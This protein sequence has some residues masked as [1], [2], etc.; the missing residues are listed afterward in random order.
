MPI[1]AFG[2]NNLDKSGY[3]F[4]T[5][6][7]VQN[8]YGRSN[9]IEGNI[10]EDINLK[11][12]DRIEKLPDPISIREAA[13]KNYVDK[14]FND[15]SIIRNTAHVDFND[16]NL[17][18]VRFIKVISMPALGKHLTASYYVDDA[19]YRRV[20]EPSLLRLDPD[21]KL[22]LGKQVSIFFILL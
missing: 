12:Q 1:N 20:H 7:F 16:K 15:P 11:N 4:D 10:Q 6:L 18:N 2:N 14:K 8:P 17:D 13:S 21:E 19:I 3:K 22:S 5:S 9:Y